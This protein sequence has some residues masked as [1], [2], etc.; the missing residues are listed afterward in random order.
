MAKVEGF[1]GKLARR[2]S[3][4]IAAALGIGGLINLLFTPLP[5]GDSWMSR[6]KQGFDNFQ[7]S[8][9]PMDLLADD[10]AGNNVIS[11]LGIQMV[12]NVWTSLPMF[13]G[14]AIAGWVGRKFHV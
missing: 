14:A 6:L 10:G 8:K 7:S 1:F 4:V 3:R 9:N 5:D 11:V 12:N 2:P 13:A